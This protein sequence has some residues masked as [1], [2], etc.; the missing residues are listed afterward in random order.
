V[1]EDRQPSATVTIG[2]EA[3]ML[4]IRTPEGHLWASWSEDDGR[5][6]SKPHPTSL[7]HPD[8][9]PMLFHLSDGET[10]IAFHHNRH[11]VTK[12]TYAGLG[13]NP[14]CFVD[15]SEIWFATSADKGHTWSAPRFLFANALAPSF[16]KPFRNYQCSYMDAVIESGTIRLIVPRR[17]ERVLCLQFAEADLATMATKEELA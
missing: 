12:E 5:T 15:R 9:P 11:S 3:V 17:W 4:M 16:E 8:A 10:L 7:V 14:E 13:S 6:W 1:S 2:G